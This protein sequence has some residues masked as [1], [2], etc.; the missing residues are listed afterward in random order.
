[1]CNIAAGIGNTLTS[2][3]PGQ[4]VPWMFEFL[5]IAPLQCQLD[6]LPVIVVTYL[7]VSVLGV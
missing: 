6:V 5:T 7:F 1:M 4:Y 3:P 2:L